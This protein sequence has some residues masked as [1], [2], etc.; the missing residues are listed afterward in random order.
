MIHARPDYD[1]I[2]DP[3]NKI[4]EKEPVFLLRGQD[5]MA[6]RAVRYWADMVE[7][8]GGDPAM[9]KAAREHADKMDKWPEKK[10]PD[11]PQTRK[12]KKK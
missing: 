9:I 10:M 8:A 1:R 4:P 12:E 3:E 7:S 11:L 2:Q 5:C 6:A